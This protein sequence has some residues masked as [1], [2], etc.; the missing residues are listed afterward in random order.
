MEAM[1]TK[2]MEGCLKGM[3]VEEREKMTACWEKMATICPCM[4]TKGSDEERK[5][6]MEKMMAFCGGKMTQM[7]ACCGKSEP[8]SVQNGSPT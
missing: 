4:G 2:M 5:A 7:S 3:S 8:A 1:F 6:M